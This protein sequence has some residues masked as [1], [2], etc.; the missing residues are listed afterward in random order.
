MPFDAAIRRNFPAG[1][2]SAMVAELNVPP[3]TAASHTSSNSCAR[4]LAR[5]IASLVALRASNIPV[6]RSFCFSAFAFS[7][8]R[9]KCPR[10]KETFSAS[11]CRSS[12]SS[13][14]N[15]P[16]SGELKMS[17]PAGRSP[18]SNGSAAHDLTPLRMA[19]SCQGLVRSSAKK[20]LLTQGCCARNADPVNPRPC[21]SDSVI[22]NSDSRISPAPGPVEATTR[23]YNESDSARA[24]VAEPNFAPCTAA[25]QTISNSSAR[26]LARMI[27]SLVALRDA[28]IRARRSVSWSAFAFLSARSKLSRANETFSASRASSATISLSA[29][30][31]LLT[32]NSNT[33]TLLPAFDKRKR[34]ASHN[35][36]LA[37]H[38]LPRPSLHRVEDIKIDARLLR[39]KRVAANTGPI[40]VIRIDREAR[41]RDQFD[42]FT[43]SRDRFQPDRIRLCK[44]GHRGNGFSAVNGGIADKLVKFLLRLGAKNCFICC[45]DGAEHPVQSSH[46]SLAALARGLAVEIIERI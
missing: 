27:A 17:T 14:V 9:S 24:T 6:R 45:A 35:A 43:G 1:S 38:L 31:D 11:R 21:G 10:A 36:G 2:A 39:S 26:D 33:P 5:M 32:K 16:N 28:N 23:R 46:G 13:G 12:T 22:A 25:W 19:L 40:D 34:N 29:A 37:S 4:V 20:S 42:N 8:A 7:S 41:P 30:Q 18:L 15:V 44:K 3:K